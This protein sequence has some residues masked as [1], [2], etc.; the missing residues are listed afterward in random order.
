MEVSSGTQSVRYAPP[1][2]KNLAHVS[3][4]YPLWSSLRLSRVYVYHSRETAELRRD[5]F[6]ILEEIPQ[7]DPDQYVTLILASAKR[8]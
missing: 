7:F 2:K 3:I 1:Q 4:P 8:F 5:I 6:K